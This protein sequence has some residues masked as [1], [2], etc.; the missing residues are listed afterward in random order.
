VCQITPGRRIV[1]S[2]DDACVSLTEKLSCGRALVACGQDSDQAQPAS[3]GDHDLPSYP[4][5]LSKLIPPAAPAATVDRLALWPAAGRDGAPAVVIVW[6]PAGYGK[7]TTMAQHFAA[8]A[9]AKRRAVWLQLDSGDN[10]SFRFTASLVAALRR[11]GLP[12]IARPAP[13]LLELIATLNEP[14]TLFM[15]E[16]EHLRDG[17]ILEIVQSIID[18]LP[19]QGQ[20]VIGTR[21]KPSLALAR[22]QAYG[23]LIEI[24]PG[25]LRFTLDESR[26][27]LSRINGAP[28]DENG[29][30]ALHA[31]ADG[32]PTG[33]V[34]GARLADATNDLAA[35]ETGRLRSANA[36]DAF[37]DE[38]VFAQ[39]APRVQDFVL[40]IGILEDLDRSV[41]EAVAPGYD[42]AAELVLLQRENLFVAPVGDEP[43]RLRFNRLFRDYLRQRLERQNPAIVP[44]LHRRAGEAL[45]RLGRP[46][47]AIWHA[48]T[49][50]DFATAI[51]LLDEE[52]EQLLAQGQ[53]RLL[54]HWFTRIPEETLAHSDRLEG[55][56]LWSILFTEGAAAAQ[57]R[58]EQLEARR[59]KS[60][61]LRAHLN[62]AR[63]FILAMADRYDEAYTAGQ[64][65]LSALPSASPIADD[66]LRVAMANVTSVVTDTGKSQRFIDAARAGSGATFITMYSEG[67]EGLLDYQAGRMQRAT[68]KFAAAMAA[69]TEI[70]QDYLTFDLWATAGHIVVLYENDQ[71]DEAERIARTYLPMMMK[72]T[73]PG[74]TSAVF[75]ACASIAFVKDDHQ[76]SAAMLLTLEDLGHRRRLP[77][78]VANARLERARQLTLRGHAQAAMEELQR[79]DDKSVWERVQRMRLPAN[80]A[81]FM[82]LARLRWTI[83]F[84]DP[85]STIAELG[86]LYIK[87]SAE[88]RIRR[89]LRVKVLE[90]IALQRSGDGLGAAE[91]MLVAL[92][93]GMSS[94][95]LRLLADEGDD[96]FRIANRVLQ[97]QMDLSVRQV[98]RNLFAYIARLV[99]SFRRPARD[100]R[101]E[102]SFSIPE[103]LTRKEMM[104]LALV[105]EGFSNAGLARRLGLSDSTIRTHLRNI[106]TKL[107]ARSRVEAVA[108]ARKLSM[109]R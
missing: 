92:R 103:P 43:G 24:G 73:L 29:L 36:L 46:M 88:H 61:D 72:A 22:A 62:A 65:S 5:R 57:P 3:R 30:I 37:L 87:S 81:D 17:D 85:A 25:A 52:A 63:P 7:T 55:I 35:I 53:M 32:W 107:G 64:A 54:R 75:T 96:V 79:A 45:R 42:A 44:D 49:A 68:E 109:I 105:S 66:F 101:A 13:A 31:R 90:A 8:L 26:A 4:V 41:C 102:V 104:V 1:G 77:R 21:T 11:A 97:Q 48:I 9:A 83:H 23:R 2:D 82:E 20:I 60:I 86:R 91:A 34:L 89:A 71:L 74:H 80:E 40:R 108:I 70:G 28:P 18:Y 50:R 38:V 95:Y 47:P 51:E 6:A 33:L 59:F 106:N 84:G 39:L 58:L 19:P 15:D 56:D 12:D 99:S 16:F 69:R 14:F 94:G 76:R 93:Q 78:L 100:E 10:D 27:L 98:D 67:M